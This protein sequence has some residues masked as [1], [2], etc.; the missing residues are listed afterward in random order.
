MVAEFPNSD[1]FI[2]LNQVGDLAILPSR[3][4]LL[5]SN[6]INTF[7]FGILMFHHLFLTNSFPSISSSEGHHPQI[8]GVRGK[9]HRGI[10]PTGEM[11]LYLLAGDDVDKR[12]EIRNKYFSPEHWLFKEKILYLEPPPPGEPR[13]AGKLVMAEEYVELFLT[14]KMGKPGFSMDFP[15][16]LI[17]TQLVWKD[18]VL[19]PHTQKQVQSL[20]NWLQH[21]ATVQK[22]LGLGD[23]IAPGYRALFYGPSGTG[24]TLTAK[25][26]GKHTGKDV[27]RV[28][29]SMVISKYIGETEKN[30]SKLFDKAE[31]KDWILF[32]DEADALFGKRTGVKDAHDR[33]ANQEISY[34][35]QRVENYNG[36]VILASNLKENIDEAFLRRFQAVI[37][38][39]MPSR[40]ERLRLWQQS[41]PKALGLAPTL[42]LN[43]YADK[44][45]LT[46]ADIINIV[47]HCCVETVARNGQELTKACLEEGIGRELVKLGKAT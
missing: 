17:T 12:I 19:H 14:G 30:L 45:E 32:F 1:S 29:L 47:H 3:T 41:I 9:Q 16:Q 23:K 25:L 40:A 22:D 13:M 26:L 38:F 46:G 37:H 20:L 15:A 43:H 21:G 11:A 42:Q 4:R 7:P 39:P 35:L 27:Y 44:Y 2:C 28:D 34:L 31:N 5:D 8:G 24:K 36:L 6:V 10:L 18:L 33:F